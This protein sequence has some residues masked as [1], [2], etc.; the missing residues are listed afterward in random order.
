MLLGGAVVAWP[1]AAGAQQ[2]ERMRRIGALMGQAEGDPDRGLRVAV[3]A[4]GLQQ[5]GWT[6]GGN[7]RIDYR[8]A[9]SDIERSRNASVDRI[10]SAV[11]SHGVWDRILH[12]RGSSQGSLQCQMSSPPMSVQGHMQ[13]VAAASQEPH[14][15]VSLPSET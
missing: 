13:T 5:L 4:Q 6:I 15:H 3:F 11:P 1:L 2:D 10:A 8:W 12:W 9:T 7:V 14:C